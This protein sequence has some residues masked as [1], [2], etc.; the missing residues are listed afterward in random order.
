MSIITISRGSYSKGKDIA[1]KLAKRLGYKCISR[2]VLIEASEDFNI[3]EIKLI[4]ALHDAPSVLDRFHYGK[5]RYVAYIKKALLESV[6]AGNIIYHGLAGHFLLGDLPGVLKV[7]IISDIEDRVNEEIKRE[8]IDRDKARYTLKKDDEE[9]RKWS[10]FLYGI[11]TWDP[12][13]YDIVI[14]IHRLKVDEAVELLYDAAKLSPFISTPESEQAFLDELL[15]ARVHVE[16]IGKFPTSKVTC[17]EGDCVVTVKADLSQG[18]KIAPQIEKLAGDMEG[19]KNLK[20]V[21]N[22]MMTV[23]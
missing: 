2:D 14:H 16:I 13:L 12:R 19:L 3:P 11:D 5:E 6:A 23:D 15:A 10:L 1:E 18:E 7:R 20:T 4:R 17:H 21:I 22:P 8:N 9:R